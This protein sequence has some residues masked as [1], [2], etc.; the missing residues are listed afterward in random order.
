MDNEKLSNR[1]RLKKHLLCSEEVYDLITKVCIKEY[2]EN[3][4][5]ME[6]AKITHNHILKQ[7]G[8]FYIK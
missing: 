8:N 6:G 4:P 2:I 5:E 3:H 7:V 1:Q